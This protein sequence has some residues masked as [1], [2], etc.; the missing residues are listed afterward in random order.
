MTK[1]HL[2]DEYTIN[3]IA[4]GEIIESPASIIKELIENSMDA[5]SS[6]IT[7]EIKDGGI[8]FI[9][10]TDNGIG[11]SRT[12]AKLALQRH[13]TSKISTA[14]DLELV[15]TLGFRGEA[16]ASIAAV[17]QFEMF[18]RAREDISGTHVINHGGE[19]ID[20]KETGCPEGTT[21][22]VRNLFYNTPARL[23]FLKST[24]AESSKISN[25]MGR[26]IMGNPN[27]SIKYI[28]NGRIIYHSPGNGSLM[29]A[30][31]AV[32]GSNITRDL[33]K[34]KK[35][36]AED[37]INISGYL[38]KPSM[39]RGNRV[40]QSF[41]VN[42]RYIH[43]NTTLTTAL[44]EAYK[45]YITTNTYPWAILHL[46]M[47]AN[48][49]D[50][51]IHPAKTEV[52]F[53]NE[54]EIY[55]TVYNAVRS[56]L[57]EGNYIPNI[58]VDRRQTNKQGENS[59]KESISLSS[60][61]IDKISTGGEYTSKLSKSHNEDSRYNKIPKASVEEEDADRT[62]I[63]SQLIEHNID[64]KIPYRVIGTFLSTYILL[65]RG[66][67]LYI[68]DQH[69]AHER[70][71]YERFKDARLKSELVVQMINPPLVIDVTHNEQIVLKHSIDV[72][73][74]LGF[75]IE[76]FGGNTFIIRGIP[77][78]LGDANIKKIFFDILD[79]IA[80]DNITKPYIIEE[81]HIITCACK[82]AIKANDMLSDKEI[83]AL[84]QQLDEV[85]ERQLTCPHGRP[86]MIRLTRYELEKYFKRV[87]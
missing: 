33:V 29:S 13:A 57:E 23:K 24:R 34:I 9:R 71:L 48:Q 50:V 51:N 56:S 49:I 85:D 21:V 64:S 11:M 81:E 39:S 42:S 35:T 14:E 19:L 5:K 69:A 74:E 78:I 22:I 66:E 38:G 27:V 36:N 3:Q 32:Y 31:M 68:V 6:A 72:F 60:S 44:E 28:N 61:V 73:R 54:N 41:F 16:L 15:S 26:L 63:N 2:L 20:I 1:V 62:C 59:K 12:D 65:E 67:S 86:I 43:R 46:S 87:I 76:S 4:A 79:N 80:E 55:Q 77:S 83:Q 10:V 7:V 82:R 25:I 17:T 47:P 40:H 84:F 8:K 45:N 58:K 53:K 37:G 18:T 70:I 30:A 75:D 52:R